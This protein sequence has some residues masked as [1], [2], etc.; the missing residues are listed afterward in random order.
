M[1]KIPEDLVE[2]GRISDAYGVQGM[3][4]V[5]PFSEQETV[6]LDVN[7][8]WLMRTDLKGK[9]LESM[10]DAQLI[11]SR[12]QGSAVVAKLKDIAD[13][14]QAQALKGTTVYISRADFPKADEDEFY[15]VDLI[16]CAVYSSQT[17]PET[18]I[19]VVTEVS[20]NGAHGVLHV[21]RQKLNASGELEGLMTAKGRAVEV[22]VP[23]VKQM[24]PVVDLDKRYIQADWPVDF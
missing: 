18:L 12:S 3:I 7:Q 20:D 24:V 2:V 9:P 22:L 6:L 16:G 4:K 11:R 10:R 19:G 8:W 1:Q 5:I 21:H 13:R 17:Q 14:D 15:W 23:F